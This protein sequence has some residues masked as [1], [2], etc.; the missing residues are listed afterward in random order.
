MRCAIY[1]RVS[2]NRDAQKNSLENQ[3]TLA[4]SL[5][6]QNGWSVT[7]HYIDDGISG[8]TRD[9]RDA[10]QRLLQD[11]KSKKFDVVIAK[12]VSRL[13]RNTIENLKTAHNIESF[14][15]RLILPEDN[16]DTQT[17]TSRL[18]FNLKAV[19][20]EEESAKLSERIK[21]GLRASAKQGIYKASL[22]AFGYQRDSLTKKLVLDENHAPIVREIFDLYLYKDWG[23]YKISNYLIGKSVPTPRTVSGGSN[24][25]VLWH[26]STVKLI[27]SNIVYTGTLVQ[28]QTETTDFISKRRK[29]VDPSKQ[30]IT[31][32]AH[33]AIITMD[34]HNAVQEKMKKKGKNKSNGQESL[35]AHIAVCAD[36]GKGMLFRK[37]RRKNGAYVCGGYVKHS[38]SF[39]SSHII[40]SN[41]LLQAVKDELRALITDNIKMEK[42]YGMANEKANAK[43]AQYSKELASITKR[44]NQLTKEFQS[45]LQL[46]T[47]KAI[48]IVQFKAQNE[49]IQSEQSQL[50]TRKA[51]LESML[52]NQKDTEQQLRAFKKQVDRFAQLNIDDEQVLKQVLQKLIHKI[53]V[54]ENG[55][56]TIHYNI[57][58]P[59]SAGA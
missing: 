18:M 55:A 10:I 34:E 59:L 13:G 4:N 29:Q 11:A 25:G 58:R 1:A 56:L 49:H 26:Q 53:E 2:T 27:L 43:Q 42:L 15:I 36:C 54:H 32:N 3:V 23:M 12:S 22:P 48:D 30:V 50:S 38:R 6:I 35:F 8:A 9:K 24:A 20:A 5:V 28:H 19:L 16:Y 46:Y 14:G 39:C 47:D 57:T 7:E 44:L 33:P 40:E 52:E 37:D 17:S 21:L 31:E 45:L 51:E 41:T